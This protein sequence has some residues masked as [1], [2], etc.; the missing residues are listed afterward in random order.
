MKIKDEYEIQQIAGKY[1][2]TAQGYQKK[3]LTDV[4]LLNLIYVWL[5]QQLTGTNFTEEEA[6]YL[7]Q[8]EYVIDFFTAKADVCS[9]IESLSENNILEQ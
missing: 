4:I 3:D 6:V 8:K 2:I 9:W 7:L 1:I 5:W